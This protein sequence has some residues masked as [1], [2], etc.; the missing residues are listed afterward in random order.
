[1][2]CYFA[3]AGAKVYLFLVS[4]AEAKFMPGGSG[5]KGLNRQPRGWN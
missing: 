4:S 3:G 5:V 1:M 2:V